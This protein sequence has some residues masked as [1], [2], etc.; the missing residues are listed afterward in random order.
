MKN[1]TLILI[2]GSSYLYRAYYAPPHL[3]NSKNEPT[4]AVFGVIHMIKHLLNQYQPEH[5]AVIFDTKGKNFRHEMYADYKANRASMPDDLRQQIKPLYQVIDAMGIPRIGIEGVEADDVI[6]TLAIQ[7]AALG[8]NTLISTGDKDMAQLVNDQ[9]HLINTM[10]NTYFK[11]AEVTQKFGVNPTQIVDFL[12]LMGDKS[13]NVPGLPGVGEK[14]AQALIQSLHSIDNIYSHLDDIKDLSF[15]GAKTMAKKLI[16]HKDSVMLSKALVTIKCDVPHEFDLAELVL[17]PPERETLIQLYRDLEFRKLL[18]EQLRLDSSTEVTKQEQPS[19]EYECI[20]SESQL[21]EWLNRLQNC[22]RFSI[23]IETTGLDYLNAS[24]VGISLAISPH[25]AAYIPVGHDVE[26][27]PKQLSK[28]YVLSH[29][30]PILENDKY[31]KI[32]QNIKYDMHILQNEGVQLQGIEFDTMLASY[33]INSIASRH[34]MHDLA[35]K[36]LGKKTSSFEDIAGKGSQQKTFN[37]IELTVA[38]D[39]ACEDA[40]ITLQL[41]HVLSP[42]LAQTPSLQTLFNKIELPLLSVLCEMER[43][44]VLLDKTQLLDQAEELAYQLEDLEQEAYAMAGEQFN[45]NS[46]K[47]LRYVFFNKLQYPILRKT[48]KGEPSTAEDVLTDLALDHELPNVILVHRSLSKLKNTY[49]DK[50]PMMIDAKTGRLHTHYHQ[51]VTTTGRLSSSEPN[52]Q[53]IPVRTQEGRRIR[54]AFVARDNHVILAADYSQIEL[55]IMA[56]LSEDASLLEAF[57]AN[58][59]IHQA[60]AAEVFNVPF[61]DVTQDQRRRAKAVNFGLIYGMSAY[62]LSQQL[63]ISRYEAQSYIDTYFERY[64]QVAVY[65]ENTRRQAEDK[66]FIETIYGR[67]LYLP[68]IKAANHQRREAAKRAAINAPMQGSAADI[69]KIAMIEVSKWLQVQ[70]N[71]HM[72]MQVHDELVFEVHKSHIESARQEVKRLMTES[73][74][75]N[76]PL[77]VDIGIA[78]SWEQAH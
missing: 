2:D 4:G 48:P 23:D 12:A 3:T 42:M 69:I 53:N 28:A 7:A 16:E 6:G 44:G 30:K 9:I 63:D 47:Q 13:D 26:K 60:T 45:L 27:A 49:L 41:Y 36:Y 5:I 57:G 35:L 72:L 65:M 17:R 78:D 22:Q 76:V 50:L 25:Q 51:A 10:N 24:L 46:T 71:V 19:L 67:R 61:A 70:P 55:R 52:L 33:V 37:Q 54:N 32:G 75:L 74:L 43:A 38:T 14:T 66:G 18:D 34:N 11:S 68:D 39:Y 20:L 64:P 1:S 73:V 58:K 29:L 62:G 59:D 56:H 40:D 31:K 15:R 21:N 77:I 8:W